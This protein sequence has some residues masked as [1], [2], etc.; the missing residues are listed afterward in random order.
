MRRFVVLFVVLTWIAIPI[1]AQVD[2]GTVSGTVTDAS[3]AVVP[4]ATVTATSLGTQNARKVQTNA[5][6]QYN[7][8]GLASGAYELSVT[9]A[10]FAPYKSHVVVTV[11]GRLSADITLQVASQTTVVEVLGEGGTQVNTQSQELSQIIT[12]VQVAQLPSLTR[13]PYDFVATAGNI[14]NG[15]RTSS[16]Q[17]QNTTG[18]GVGYAINGQRT[19]GTE[20]LL[21]GVENVDLF[22]A[23]YGQTI[24]VDAV[25]EFRVI[26]SNFDAQYGRAS[27]G[28]VNLTTKSGTNSF[29]GSAWEFNRLSAYTANTFDNDAKGNPKGGYTRNQFGWSIGGPIK[30]DK[31]FIFQTTE[32]TR[33]RSGASLSA[34]VPTPQ[35]L[36]LLPANVQAYFTAYGANNFTFGST[37]TAAQVASKVSS[38]P[39][40][41]FTTMIPAATPVLGLVNYTANSDAGGGNPQNTYRIIGKIDFNMTD[42]TQMFFRYALESINDFTGADFTSPYSK[43]DVG[44]AQ[45]NNAGLYSLNHTFSNNVFSN[46]K[47]SFSRLNATQTYDLSAQNVPELLISNG[48]SVGGTPVL[49]PGLWAQFAGAGGEPYGGPQNVLQLNHDLSWTKGRHNLR[50]G[51]EYL[52]EQSNRAYGAYAQG[53]EQLGT[54]TKQ[55]FDNI[56]LGNLALFQA[57]IYPQGKLPCRRNNPTSNALIVTPACEI[58]LP[59]TPPSFARSFRYN[60]WAIYAQ[61]SFRMTHRLTLNYGLRYEHYG[62]QHNNN[63]KL[64]SNFYFGSG[65]NVFEQIRNGQIAL[66]PNSPVGG[67]WHPNWGTA[68]PRIGFAYDL[69]GD[70]KTSLRGGFGISYERNFGNV[71]FNVIQN[72]PNYASVQLTPASLGTTIPVTTSNFGPFG[73]SA[74]T[75]VPLSP[76][77]LRHVNQNIDT[78]QTQFYSLAVERQL[79]SN[80]VL[81]LEYSGA[82]GVHLYDIAAFNALGRGNVNLGDPLTPGVFSRPNPQY[83]GINTRGSNGTSRYNAM[84]VRLQSTNLHHTG[85]SIVANYTWSHAMDDLSSTFADSTGGASAG[86]GNLGYLDPTHPKLDWGSADYDI[87]HRIAI[88]TI[89]ETPWFKSGSGWKRQA[90]G[91]WTMVPVFT[92]RTGTPFSVFDTTNSINASS[93]YGIPRYVPGGS[94][95]SYQVG[96]ASSANALGPNDYAVLTLPAANSFTGLLGISDF[97][98]YPSNMTR[99]NAFRG[100][101]AWNADFALTKSFPVTER[102][103][104]EFRAEGFDI[105]NH[106]NLYANALNFDAANFSSGPVIIDAL[107]GG[108]GTNNVLGVNHDERRFGQFALR[109]T[110]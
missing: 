91:G 108:L 102:L 97:G 31:L 8:A 41:A 12:P 109:I 93:G 59:A 107:K 53:L 4:N 46:T 103:K 67:M 26:T 68:A 14:S 15:D 64:D 83:S 87:R 81:A 88:S 9:S 96:S 18:R 98:P 49:F 38:S 34:Y 16:G 42:R 70:G 30:K 57:A 104:L 22:T 10:N 54:S 63:Q 90:L 48:G 79:A 65:A 94:I 40:G 23:L 36:S 74:G 28:V 1:L 84:N 45:Y 78:A 43:Y 58:T 82:H 92:A 2:T 50:F 21:D 37:L 105:F 77:S 85:L 72:V 51:G 32:F 33:V 71:T 5:S 110:F 29:H 17:D 99:R 95:P 106:H 89:W 44:D 100:P 60:D 61:D 73:G 25:Q 6:G 55:G 86:I 39:T 27:G 47:I 7:I 62:V 20:V 75:L 69:F 101:G 11:G 3:G 56:V 19:S 35:F 13:N 76:S 66:A 24:P 80:T 52:Y